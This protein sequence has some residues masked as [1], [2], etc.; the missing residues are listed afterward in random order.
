MAIFSQ[1]FMEKEGSLLERFLCKLTKTPHTAQKKLLYEILENNKDTE[2]GRKYNFANINSEKDFQKTI[3]IN[4]YQDLEPYIEKV[5]NGHNNVLTADAPVMFNLTSGTSSKPKYIPVT[6]KTKKRTD[7]LMRQWLYKALLD[8]PS[9][10]NESNLIITSAPVE[11]HSYSGI[12]FGSLSGQIYNNL[13][14]GIMDRYALPFAVAKI[15]DYDLRYYAMAR[16]VFEKD[17]SFIATPNPTTLMRLADIGMQY[18]EEIIR[19]IQDGFLFMNLDLEID[20][21][22]L[23][24]VKLLNSSLRPNK[25]RARFLNN[26]VKNNGK[27][28]PRYCWT[29]LKLIGCWL[30]GSVGRYAEKLSTYYGDA[31]KRDLGYLASEGSISLPYEDS[32]PSGILALQNNYYEFIE[33]DSNVT[34]DS[35]V[36]LSH[37]LEK[38]KLYKVLLTNESGL[39]RYDINDTIR[40]DK[41]YNQTPVLAFVSKTNDVLNITGEKLHLNQLL[42]VFKKL[43]SKF[44]VSISQ[45][46]VASNKDLI[47][48]EIFV[49]FDRDISLERLRNTILPSIDLFL[50]EINIE[51]SQKRKSK[52]L[53]PP[54]LHVMEPS[55]QEGIKRKHIVSGKRDVQ[56]KWLSISSDLLEMDKQYV[57]C[58]ID[59]G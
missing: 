36:L 38:G 48:H 7:T 41:F 45:F 53:N 5:F 42:M 39:Y 43:Q 23:E 10:L 59:L 44:N 22:D 16:L 14:I 3:P 11:G 8:H 57:K 33:E 18:Q 12:P 2:Y 21:H 55:W 50:S 34:S 4:N 26:V 35:R 58:T 32:T 49:A 54:C 9:F 6:A 24:I 47:R 13:P 25:S 29:S 56:Y 37:E 51:Y 40:V 52:R 31:S 19:S 30:G 15:K 46:R 17:V 1:S 20:A 27:L 28:L